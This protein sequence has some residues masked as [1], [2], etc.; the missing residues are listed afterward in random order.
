[1]GDTDLL[2]EKKNRVGLFLLNRPKALNALTYEMFGQLRDTLDLWQK[3]PEIYGV[4]L[5]AVEGRAF[6]A[7][8]DIRELYERGGRDFQQ[9]CEMLE[10]EYLYNWQLNNFTKPHIALIDGMTLGGGV[11]ISLYG[12]H[13]VAGRNFSLGMPEASIGFIPDVGGSWFLGHMPYSTGLYLALTGRSIERS[14][15]Y[16]MGLVTHTV[17]EKHFPLIKDAVREGKP[18]DPLLDKLHEDPGAGELKPLRSWI[19][20]VFSASS[21]SEIFGRAKSLEDK[22]NGWSRKVLDEMR[23]RSPTSLFLAHRLWKKGR[24]LNL[25]QALQLEYTV[26]CNLIRENDFFE[27][28]RA[29]VIDKDQNPKWKPPTIEELSAREV[30]QLLENRWG[31]LE[32]PMREEMLT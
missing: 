20:A 19:E 10:R 5:E 29:Q 3:D 13:R 14:D 2:V 25:R 7:G 6:C 21:L 28:I 17:N 11:G 9:A 24:N 30:E 23:L 26:V 32:L 18:I 31:E 4:V 12:T 15:A 27:G 16:Q 22:T 1:M 8:G